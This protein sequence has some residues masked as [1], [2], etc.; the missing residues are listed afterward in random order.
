MLIVALSVSWFRSVAILILNSTS[1]ISFCSFLKQSLFN[2][3]CRSDMGFDQQGNPHLRRML[4]RSQDAGP[5][6]FSRQIVEEGNVGPHATRG[7]SR[8]HF[9]NFTPLF[10]QFSLKSNSTI[11]LFDFPANIHLFSLNETRRWCTRCTVTE[12]TVFGSTR[13]SIPPTANRGGESLKPR[14]P[15]SNDIQ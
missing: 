7:W 13:C 15:S 11:S 1:G 9:F 5:A 8:I 6:H 14:I 12:P 2:V 3:Y 4:R 10:Y